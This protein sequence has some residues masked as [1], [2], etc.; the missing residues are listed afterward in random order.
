MKKEEKRGSGEK[1]RGDYILTGGSWDC[2]SVAGVG[3]G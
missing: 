1:G 2:L 3:N